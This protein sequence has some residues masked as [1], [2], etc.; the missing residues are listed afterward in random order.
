MPHGTILLTPTSIQ[1][2]CQQKRPWQRLKVSRRGLPCTAAFACT[3]YKVQS[4][5]LELV[6]LEL[7]GTRT[8]RV[9]GKKEPSPGDPYG[10]HGPLSRCPCLDCPMVGSPVWPAG[11][12]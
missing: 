11:P 1:I 12:M 7:R 9:N 3:D 10:L 8:T 5:T 4:R 2:D 6:A